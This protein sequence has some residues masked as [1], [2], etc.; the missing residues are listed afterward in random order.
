[1]LRRRQRLEVQSAGG[2]LPGGEPDPRAE[3][4]RR[5]LDETRAVVGEQETFDAGEV[6]VDRAEPVPADPDELRARVHAEG[7]A[8]ADAMR[9][10]GGRDI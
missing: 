7:R 9:R 10:A 4:L 3:A 5:R 8:A 6:P 2:E 1:M